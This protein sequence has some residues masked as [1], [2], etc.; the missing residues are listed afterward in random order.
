MINESIQQED[1]TILN[2]YAPNAMVPG[3]LKQILMDLRG[4]TDSNTIAMVNFNTTVSS[5]VRSIRQ[6]INRETTELIYAMN[7]MDLTDINRIISLYVCRIHI[8]F[9]SAWNF[10]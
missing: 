7:Q 2:V 1:V 4:D 3:Y 6:K 10:L 5:I 9:I 8:L